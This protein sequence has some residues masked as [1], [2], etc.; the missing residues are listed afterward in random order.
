MEAPSG[1]LRLSPSLTKRRQLGFALVALGFGVC[2]LMLAALIQLAEYLPP[3]VQ[4]NPLFAALVEGYAR[5]E[6]FMTD[7]SGPRYLG[8][9]GMGIGIYWLLPTIRWRLW[10]LLLYSAFLVVALAPLSTLFTAVN[11]QVLILAGIIA[12]I[13]YMHLLARAAARWRG[14]AVGG[15]A[16][17][18]LV[19]AGILALPSLARMNLVPYSIG[20]AADRYLVLQNFFLF[21]PLKS[22][23][24]LWDVAAGRSDVYPLKTVALWFLFFPG[25]RNAP[26]ERVQPFAAQLEAAPQAIV[27][28]RTGLGL[29]RILI[30]VFKGACAAFVYLNLSPTRVWATPAEA[31][32]GQLWL[33][34][35]GYTFFI[36]L[37]FSGYV[38]VMIGSSIL[39]G[40]HLPENFHR[41]YLQSDVRGFWR[42]WNIVAS[43]W[44]RDYVYIPLGGSRSGNVYLN[45]V[46]T[47]LVA[48]AWHAFRL[49]FVIWGVWHGLGLA[50]SRYLFNRRQ[51]AGRPEPSWTAP[52]VG[53][54]LKWLLGAFVTFHFV[55]IGWV[56][57]HN[58]YR[59]ISVLNSLDM[60]ARMFGLR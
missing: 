32:V 45:L 5:I 57:H 46:T 28:G 53:L 42:G 36:Y 11:M 51:Q 10:F 1:V 47:M 56:F 7:Y 33:A 37:T 40:Y 58:G 16:G 43:R 54:R 9:L 15:I 27:P 26:F 6:P 23:H 13:L 20:Q 41:P 44:L 8:L 14:F 35:Y 19:Y 38:D 25:F 39:L 48:G 18:V 22:I 34:A 4:A 49:N 24:Y 21:L 29:K 59:V 17:I 3:A 2:V 31:S 50:V 30:G 55:T 52:A 12:L 60:L